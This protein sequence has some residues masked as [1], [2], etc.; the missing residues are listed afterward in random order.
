[1]ASYAYVVVYSLI[2]TIGLLKNLTSVR[3]SYN[4]S[5]LRLYGFIL[6]GGS[7][8]SDNSNGIIENITCDRIN[9]YR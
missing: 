5:F 4:E 6:L 8:E 2:T 7:I 9:S 3:I 1:M